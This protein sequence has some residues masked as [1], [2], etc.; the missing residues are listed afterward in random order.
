M[1]R[2]SQATNDFWREVVDKEHRQLENGHCGRG[3]RN[4]FLSEGVKSVL[5]GHRLGDFVS[6]VPGQA[7]A[8]AEALRDATVLRRIQEAKAR[9][10][11]RDTKCAMGVTRRSVE[12]SG[13]WPLDPAAKAVD[14]VGLERDRVALRLAA[15]A[16]TAGSVPDV[17]RSA[18]RSFGS[19]QSSAAAAKGLDVAS[20]A[21]RTDASY[22]KVS[23][24]FQQH[25]D[26]NW[27]GTVG[28]G[29]TATTVSS[30]A[31]PPDPASMVAAGPRLD[32]IIAARED[33]LSGRLQR[34]EA[35]RRR[36]AQ[37]SGRDA[38]AAQFGGHV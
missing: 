28:L 20:R 25:G 7:A 36:L 35:G 22:M 31:A 26:I 4:H 3:R 15:V 5:G 8:I 11:A 10:Q 19:S 29:G 13:H 30:A 21:V 6:E 16:A 34:T 24:T 18:R 12:A 1:Q 17:S 32:G 27:F 14:N 9:R 37:L 2:G 38:A 33:Q 23:P